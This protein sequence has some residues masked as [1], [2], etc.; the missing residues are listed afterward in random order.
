MVNLAILFDKGGMICNK[1]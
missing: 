1:G